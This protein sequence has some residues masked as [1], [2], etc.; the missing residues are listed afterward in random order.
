MPASERIREE[1]AL[2]FTRAHSG[3]FSDAERASRD[4]WLSADPLHRAEYAALDRVW[5]AAAAVPVGRLRALAEPGI[6][7]VGP[8]VVNRRASRSTA[9]R[10][11]AVACVCIFAIGL[12][13]MMLPSVT[14]SPEHLAQLTPSGAAPA[15]TQEIATRPGERRS[16]TLA[17]GTVVELNTRTHIQVRFTP[18]QRTVTLL[19]GEAM[20]SVTRDASRPFV[21]DAGTGRVTVTGTRFDVRRI[22]KH[23][24]VAVESGSVTVD[25]VPAQTAG[26]TKKTSALLTKGLGTTVQPD[27][28]VASA[29]PVDLS[30]ALAWRDGKLIFRNATLADVAH[31]VTLYRPSPVIVAND[32]V[33]QLRVTSVFSADNTDELLAALPQFLPVRVQTLTDGTVKISS[34]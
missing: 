27:G 28:T 19:D 2:W 22:E 6:A 26:A 30:T 23:V 14:R 3:A 33:G 9:G 5:Q 4:A 16:V 31:E 15:Q 1:A 10:W 11:I 29:S 12:G 21:V 24:S 7:D 18:A 8:E 32:A 13:A 20:F 25:G 17:D 34:K